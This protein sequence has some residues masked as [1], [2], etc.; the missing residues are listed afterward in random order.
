MSNKSAY[1]PK[2]PNVNRPDGGGQ[3]FAD[4]LN[5][6]VLRNEDNKD[7]IVHNTAYRPHPVCPHCGFVEYQRWIPNNDNHCTACGETFWIT[8]HVGPSLW[9]TNTQIQQVFKS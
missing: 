7:R 1:D 5:K 9:S 6:G 3:A 4:A 8:E 2:Y